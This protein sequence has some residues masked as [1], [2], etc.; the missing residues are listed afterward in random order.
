MKAENFRSDGAQYLARITKHEAVFGYRN[1]EIYNFV[2]VA[3]K[4]CQV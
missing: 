2:V 3:V 4:D 1:Y